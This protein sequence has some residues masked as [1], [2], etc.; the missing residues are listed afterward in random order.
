ML[1]PYFIQVSACR[2]QPIRLLAM[3]AYLARSGSIAGFGLLLVAMLLISV[4]Q[5]AMAQPKRPLVFILGILGSQLSEA[6]GRVV[7]GDRNSLLNFGELEIGPN[8][9]IK[10]LHPDGLVQGI[11]VLGQFWVIYQYGGLLDMLHKLGYVDN[12]TLF[13]FPYDWR[14]SNFDTA[15][16]F[17]AFVD[18]IPTLE[19]ANSTSWCIAWAASSRR[20]GYFNTAAR[21]RSTRRSSWARLFKGA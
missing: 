21:I 9:S 17:G 8:G 20:F 5:S 13:T 7:W 19:P 2:K 14:A 16:A 6:D 4:A 10:A 12:Q 3:R 15:Q 18:R 11:N 1:S